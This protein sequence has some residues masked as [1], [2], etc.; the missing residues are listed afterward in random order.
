MLVV[1]GDL[2]CDIGERQYLFGASSGDYRK[3]VPGERRCPAI[4]IASVAL[5]AVMNTGAHPETRHTRKM[6]PTLFEVA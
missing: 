3:Y 2:E 6:E 5:F 1:V 4:S